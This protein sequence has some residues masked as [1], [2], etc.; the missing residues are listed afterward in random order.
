MDLVTCDSYFS[1]QAVHLAVHCPLIK[2][3]A[4]AAAAKQTGQTGA[5][6]PA[7]TRLTAGQMRVADAISET[8]LD[9]LWYGAK[10]YEKAI[11]ALAR[12]ISQESLS[13]SPSAGLTT[14]PSA[15]YG[16]VVADAGRE[17][18]QPAFPLVAACILCQYEELS[19]T[20]RA[21]S[22]HLDGICKLLQIDGKRDVEGGGVRRGPSQPRPYQSP[23]HQSVFW[24][25]V[26][27][28]FKESLISQRRT[29]VDTE[30]LPLWRSMGLRQQHA[31][32][33]SALRT[34]L[35]LSC[36][37]VNHAHAT[38]S[39][40]LDRASHA[41][42]SRALAS[43]HA[44]RP[45]SFHPV[46]ALPRAAATCALFSTETW[47]ASPT[48]AFATALYH[49]A[50]SVVLMSG[51]CWSDSEKGNSGGG[52][53]SNLD[54]ITAYHALQRRRRRLARAVFAAVLGTAEGEW[55]VRMH[56]VQPLFVAAGGAGGGGG[57]GWVEAGG[58]AG[59][60]GGGR[61]EGGRVSG[62]VVGGW[63]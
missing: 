63:G 23:A 25:F 59:V 15:I 41:A 60:G 61:G 49:T 19:A 27:S 9:Y 47:Y 24:W 52:P 11:Q 21:W 34:L 37:A 18:Q 5:R 51:P 20:M 3:S 28:D 22:G 17:M 55:R 57:G 26:L 16:A 8:K 7:R 13:S 39:N 1:R 33:Q 50:Q 46:S 53:H 62:G 31:D 30:D 29:R 4:C 38:A 2:Y 6:E 44:A 42:L 58:G 32:E 36:K 56:M 12:E 10:Y 54:L 35:H 45:P 14:S 40:Q 43:W 48:A